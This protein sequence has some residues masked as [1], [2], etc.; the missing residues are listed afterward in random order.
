ML[1]IETYLFHEQVVNLEALEVN[2]LLLLPHSGGAESSL[3]WRGDL[4]LWLSFLGWRLVSM[5]I[6]P[7]NCRSGRLPLERQAYMEGI[8]S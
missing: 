4:G 6:E 3:H 8:K 7:R 2:L 5:W 1:S